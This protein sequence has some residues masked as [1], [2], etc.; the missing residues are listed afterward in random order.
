MRVCF[1]NTMKIFH[2]KCSNHFKAWYSES[3]TRADIM[4]DIFMCRRPRKDLAENWPRLYRSRTQSKFGLLTLYIM[5]MLMKMSHLAPYHKVRWNFCAC[6]SWTLFAHN[7]FLLCL[8]YL[9]DRELKFFI[10][11]FLC[12]LKEILLF[13]K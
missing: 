3:L 7:L 1:S 13:L 6:F 2:W 8:Q 9:Q 10:Y 4:A 5:F 12:Q 11:D